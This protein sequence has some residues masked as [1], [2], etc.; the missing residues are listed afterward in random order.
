ME[1]G[2]KRKHIKKV[3]ASS[4][5]AAEFGMKEKSSQEVEKKEGHRYITMST[6]AALKENVEFLILWHP[7]LAGYMLQFHNEYS[8]ISQRD[9]SL[10]SSYPHR[11]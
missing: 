3:A 4:K 2:I 7:V 8:L 6:F 1:P 11:R 5:G 9:P 10:R